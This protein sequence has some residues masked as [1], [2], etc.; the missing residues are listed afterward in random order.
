VGAAAI[1]CLGVMLGGLRAALLLGNAEGTGFGMN[2]GLRLSYHPLERDPFRSRR[3]PVHK[4]PAP[5][6]DSVCLKLLALRAVRVGVMRPSG[7]TLAAR[8]VK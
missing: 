2:L 8:P 7:Q 3:R 6:A 4:R 1:V 5:R